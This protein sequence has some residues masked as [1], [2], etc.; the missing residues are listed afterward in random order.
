[1]THICRLRSRPIL[2]L[3]LCSPPLSDSPAD[4]SVPVA[5]PEASSSPPLPILTEAPA[6]P[7]NQ[8]PP[9]F[10]LLPGAMDALFSAWAGANFAASRFAIGSIRS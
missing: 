5:E 1:M 10:G 7:L 4:E 6:P 8:R 2:C 9:I 3:I